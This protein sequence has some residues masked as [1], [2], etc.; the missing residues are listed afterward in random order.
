MAA[1]I[2]DPGSCSFKAGFAGENKPKAIISSILNKQVGIHGIIL[3]I[4]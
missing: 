1:V 3:Q 4:F 2:I